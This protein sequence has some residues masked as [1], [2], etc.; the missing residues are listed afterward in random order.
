MGRGK[1]GHQGNCPKC[2]ATSDSVHGYSFRNLKHFAIGVMELRS[3]PRVSFRCNNASCSQKTFSV[4]LADEGI[5]EVV[6]RSRYTASSKDFVTNKMLKRQVSYNSLQ[7]QL[8]EDFGASTSLSSLHKWTREK[9]TTD[10]D[11]SMSEVVVLHTDEKHPSKKKKK[12]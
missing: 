11:F 5:G 8:K 12:R 9:P 1:S 3:Y 6:G 7:L 4:L 2:G 10:A